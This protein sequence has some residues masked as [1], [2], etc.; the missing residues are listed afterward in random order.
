MKIL[1]RSISDPSA[2]LEKQGMKVDELQLPHHI[3]PVLMSNLEESNQS[4]PA[5]ARKLREWNV[6]LLR[7]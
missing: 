6:G 1:Y 3:L 7:R 2:V 5:S 4:M